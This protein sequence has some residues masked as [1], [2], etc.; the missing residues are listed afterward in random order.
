M[1]ML[2]L[3]RLLGMEVAFEDVDSF[4]DMKVVFE[5]ID[6]RRLVGVEVVFEYI[7]SRYGLNIAMTFSKAI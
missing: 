2:L 5:D 4:L 6:S 1:I 3:L 7:Y